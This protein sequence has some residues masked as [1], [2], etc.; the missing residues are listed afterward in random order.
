M[1]IVLIE[2]STVV[3]PMLRDRLAMLTRALEVGLPARNGTPGIHRQSEEHKRWNRELPGL[4]VLDTGEEGRRGQSL[5][6][7]VGDWLL[8]VPLIRH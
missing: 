3:T 1:N 2:T 4:G 8:S 5:L 7:C 6:D